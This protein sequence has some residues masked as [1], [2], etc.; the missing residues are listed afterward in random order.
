MTSQRSL[1]DVHFGGP[2]QPA[3]VLR[4]LLAAR[5][6]AVPAGGEVNWVTYYFR[7]RPLAAELAR[8][9]RRGVMVRL[10]LEGRPRVSSANAA[11]IAILSGDNGLGS[12]LRVIVLPGLPALGG[13][14]LKPRVHEK[15]YCFSH[16]EP[17]VLF[18]SFNPSSDEPES[19]PGVLRL[20]GDHR[21]AHNALVESRDPALVESLS[22]HV[23][24]LHRDGSSLF[25][26]FRRKVVRECD[27]GH[28]QVYFWPRTGRHPV[29]CLLRRAGRSCRVRIATSHLSHSGAISAITAL[30]RRGAQ[31]EVLGEHTARRVSQRAERTLKAAGIPFA[32]L[33]AASNVPMHLKFVLLEDGGERRTAC[34]SFNWTRPSYWLNH[35]FAAVTRD[36][37][38]FAAF[39]RRWTELQSMAD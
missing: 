30:A 10:V 4:D 36:P 21:I 19:E 32:R 34:G 39:D 12:G 7:D 33:G 15:I 35:E 24:A 27:F 20:I 13:L 9:A 5:L 38:V 29:E 25:F 23:R 31:V 8:A 6:A 17:T 18:G 37:G 16:P 2:D 3:G 26:R 11:V 28:T 14:A 1:F 22:G